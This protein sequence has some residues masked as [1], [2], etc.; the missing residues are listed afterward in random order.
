MNAMSAAVP[1]AI[2]TIGGRF[3]GS[4]LVSSGPW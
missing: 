4:V 2:I 3:E 1:M